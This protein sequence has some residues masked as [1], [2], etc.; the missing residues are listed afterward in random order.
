MSTSLETASNSSVPLLPLS[1]LQEAE[2]IKMLH[3]QP[4]ELFEH[5]GRQLI[6]AEITMQIHCCTCYP[7]HSRTMLTSL[8]MP[9]NTL[10]LSRECNN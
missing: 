6:Y 10:L 4:G 9:L 5:L 7:G 1:S 3:A 8:L 2:M